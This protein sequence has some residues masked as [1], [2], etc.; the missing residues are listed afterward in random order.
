MRVNERAY[1][2]F[3]KMVEDPEG[4]GINVHK[5][6]NGST[7]IDAGVEVQ[8]S[9][10]AGKIVT[11]I[12]M[13]GI[14]ET[15]IAM[16]S[17]GGMELPT[18]TVRTDQPAISLLACQLAGWKIQGKDEIWYVSGPARAIVQK[19]KRLLP[20]LLFQQLQYK[21]EAELAVAFLE[22][23]GQSLPGEAEA[24]LVAESCNVKPQNTFI[25]VA[26]TSSL[27]G[28]VQISGRVAEMGLYKLSQLGF[29]PL[30]V[31]NA[32]GSAPIAPV[33]PDKDRAIGMCNDC[34]ILAGASYYLIRTEEGEGIEQ[35]IRSV[36]S[37]SS[38]NYGKPF[39]D[40]FLEAGKD[41]HKIDP[42][43]FSPAQVTLNDIRTGRAL[44]AGIIDIVLL[45]RS[46]GI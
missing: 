40:V 2:L 23:I 29:D 27:T 43:L 5:L 13:G 15:S 22:P 11:E 38:N 39:Y 35:L 46:L 8:G 33:Q 10:A 14:G 1:N 32:V 3:A 6:S 37:S 28:S 9:F 21:D 20:N 34:I 19:P 4:Y 24:Q 30:K 25:V 31:K 42:G 18:I 44:Q 26:S 45:K 17:Y 16:K 41:F 7:I 36:P 12:C